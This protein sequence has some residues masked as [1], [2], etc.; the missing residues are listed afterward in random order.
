M[1][2]NVSGQ[3]LTVFAFDATTNL[4]KTG[5]AANITAYRDLDDGGV[6]VLGDTSATEK[7]ATNAKGY[8]IFDLTQAET[9]GDKILFSAKSSTS[10]IVVIAVPAIVYTFPTTGIL[11]PATSG[12]TLVVDASGLADANMVKAGPTGSGTA[13]TAGDIYSKVSGLTFTVSNKLDSNVYTWNGTA[14]SAPA[15]AGIPEVNVKNINNVAAATPGASGGILISGSNAGTTTFGALTVTG[16]LTVTGTTVH[17]G[18]VS[19]AAGLTITQSSSN[20]SGL[21]VTGNGTGHGILATS[22]SGATGNGIKAISAASA[23]NGIEADGV[24][25]GD[26]IAANGG[27]SGSGIH[28]TGGGAG[29]GLNLAAGSTGNGLAV[30][31]GGSSGA[32][33]AVSTTSGDGISVTPTAGHGLTLTGQGT[34]KHGLNAT[35]GATTSHGASFTGGGVGHGILATSGG[36]ATG[37]GIK[38]IAASSNGN[39]LEG[40]KSGSGKDI[41]GVLQEVTL[42]DSVSGSVGSVTGAVGSVTGAVGSVTGNVGG[43][44]TGSVGSVVGAVGSVT[45]AVGSVTGN[46]GGNVTGSVGSV[47]SGGISSASFAAGAI[48]AA[49]VATDAIDADALATDAV[50]EIADG[51]LNRDMSVG[52]DSGSTT[53]RTVRQALRAQRNK[54]DIA[55]GTLTVYKEDDATS[56]WTAAV[57]TDVAA[58]PITTVD[59]A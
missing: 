28:A 58:L 43:N 29:A 45:G 1:F 19:M 35:G 14:V 2:K 44:V 7:D 3:K 47:A 5:D 25:S 30:A 54:V 20:G 50:T 10:N 38:A 8:Y 31:G 46:V 59:P 18:N 17:T 42:A 48:N 52:S 40:V 53:V 57:T 34:T 27:T 41:A 26:G 32:G 9:N 24:G 23:G 13:Q 6:T 21:S 4:P 16:S 15:T 33:I 55:A 11:A 22:G 51:L 39:G 56:S 12:R 36:G 49:A 37:D